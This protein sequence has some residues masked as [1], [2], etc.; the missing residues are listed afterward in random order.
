MK[1]IENRLTEIRYSIVT[2]V[3]NEESVLPKTIEAVINQ[4]IQPQKWVILDDGST[5][6]TVDILDFYCEQ[7][8]WIEVIHTT[9]TVPS[10][11]GVHEKLAM[12][13]DRIGI[14]AND[15]IGKLDADI[16]I[17]PSYYEDIMK[18]FSQDPKLGIA[19][20][21]LFNLANG[22]TVVEKQPQ[23]HVR[24]G[25][26]FY[27]VECWNDIGGME[28]KLGYDTIDEI[29]AAMRGWK[30]RSYEDIMALHCRPTGQA[31]GAIGIYS[32]HGKLSYL[33]GYHPL[34]LLCKAIK[35]MRSKP[36][37]LSGMAE[38]FGFLRCYLYKTERSIDDPQLIRFLRKMQI[39]RLRFGKY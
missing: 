4:T 14:E 31:K 16:E 3:R 12:A 2:P 33:V 18:Q 5:D 35:N 34:F 32:Y 39:N 19:G 27:K 30:T 20:G 1:N 21:T 37:F 11:K 6:G 15:F 13:F 28:F 38:I 23:D 29:K 24:G 26:K 9:K 22:R 25:L 17:D 36:Y 10:Y 7:H 8:A